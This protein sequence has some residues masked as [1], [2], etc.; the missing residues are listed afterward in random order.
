MNLLK[1]LAE[2]ISESTDAESFVE[3]DII[4]RQ[5]EMGKIKIG[6]TEEEAPSLPNPKEECERIASYWRGRASSMSDTELRTAIGSDLE[7][8]EYPVEE[9]EKMIP[10]IIKMIR[11]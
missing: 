3:A 2:D 1:Q 11:K 4:L 7:S 5:I 10:R 9:V 8:I 6:E